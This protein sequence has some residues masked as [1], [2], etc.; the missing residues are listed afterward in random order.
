MAK[1]KLLIRKILT[2]LCKLNPDVVFVE[3]IVNF[4]AKEYL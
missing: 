4:A 1:E 2:K 3:G